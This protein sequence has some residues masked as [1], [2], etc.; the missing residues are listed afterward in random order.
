[1]T[2]VVART[3]TSGSSAAAAEIAAQPAAR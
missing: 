1:M 2:D 3:G